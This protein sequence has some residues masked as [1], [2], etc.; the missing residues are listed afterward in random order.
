MSLGFKR[1]NGP[2]VSIYGCQTERWMR[3]F[4]F[5]APQNSYRRNAAYISNVCYCCI[6]HLGGHII[7]GLTGSNL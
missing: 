6:I 4:L 5:Y 3:M 7:C 2:S 1:L